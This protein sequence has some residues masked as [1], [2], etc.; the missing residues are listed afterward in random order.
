MN[1]YKPILFCSSHQASMALDNN[2]LRLA[3]P[4]FDGHYDHW[5]MLIENFLRP[6]EYWIIVEI[7]LTE[8]T[9]R[10]RVE[11]K[12]TQSKELFVSSY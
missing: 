10:V 7:G 4:C 11:V 9:P 8:P 6:K 12:G 3:I 2:Y 5:R 1:F